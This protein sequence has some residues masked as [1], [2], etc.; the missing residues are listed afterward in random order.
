MWSDESLDLKSRSRAYLDINCAHC[1]NK[2]GA[3]N[4][5]GLFLSFKNNEK[6]SYGYCKQPV[7]AG[8]GTEGGT[9]DISPGKPHDSVLYLRMKSKDP[10]VMMPELGRHLVDQ[11]GFNLIYRWIS[12]IKGNCN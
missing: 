12:G 6:I 10:S 5:S 2:K 11:E 1:H 3:G 9:Y 8:K 7:A 4:T